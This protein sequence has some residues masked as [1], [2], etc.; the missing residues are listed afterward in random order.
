M[1]IKPWETAN[2]A[3]GMMKGDKTP[4]WQWGNTGDKFEPRQKSG[5]FF[6]GK[7]SL[8]RQYRG[9]FGSTEP[10]KRL[11]EMAGEIFPLKA[12]PCSMYFSDQGHE[13]GVYAK[14]LSVVIAAYRFSWI[15]GGGRERTF[16][17]QWVEGA[18]GRRQLMVYV[19]V[20]E[21]VWVGPQMIT[22]TGLVTKDMGAV[23]KEHRTWVA[24]VTSE[25]APMQAF[26][27]VLM[28][29]ET[30]MRG[31]GKQSMGTTLVRGDPPDD[32]A[33]AFVGQALLDR[34][35]ANW[36]DLMSWAKAWQVADDPATSVDEAQGEVESG[37]EE[38]PT[39]LDQPPIEP[40]PERPDMRERAKAYKDDMPLTLIENNFSSLRH[41]IDKAT[42]FLT[43]TNLPVWNRS[44]NSEQG[45]VA[46]AL[47][48]EMHK[49]ITREKSPVDEIVALSEYIAK[50]G[51]QL[52]Q[53]Y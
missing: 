50:L 42:V 51:T 14:E 5:G 45:Q 24:R 6:M 11:R 3:D 34:I 10:S 29:G 19:E 20:D 39:C 30:K 43:D 46:L 25:T 7:T 52:A 26:R 40:I 17:K 21:G 8:I 32:P 38:A 49:A 41:R 12:T 4:F 22:M 53:L 1:G 13:Q 28:V 33:E 36:G 37:Y 23:I 47:L 31:T 16:P 44:W 48:A 18:R 15:L 2:Y 35:N 27:V 9:M